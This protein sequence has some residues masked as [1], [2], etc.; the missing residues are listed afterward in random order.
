MKGDIVMYVAIECPDF[1]M[2]DGVGIVVYF[3][4][5]N[6]KCKKCDYINML[7]NK[8]LRYIIFD[9]VFDVIEK[10]IEYI[11]NIIISGGEPLLFRNEM[12]RIVYF[13]KKHKKGVW[14]Y[15][16]LFRNVDDIIDDV[17]KVV[18]DVK[19]KDILEIMNNCNCD[20]N[21]AQNIFKNYKKYCNNNK[22]IFRLSEYIDSD[23][24]FKNIEKYK[25]KNL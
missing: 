10:Y 3:S 4:E 5:C 9:E 7:K 16:N 1:L 17:N 24:K 8:D 18:V 12:L 23:I 13:A 14:I 19:G 11:D 6:L 25:I 21:I 15:T 2:S 20:S 22:F